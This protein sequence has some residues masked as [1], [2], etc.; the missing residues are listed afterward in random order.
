[1]A[2][3]LDSLGHIVRKFRGLGPKSSPLLIYRPTAINSFMTK[4]PII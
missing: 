2:I 1:M 3:L 4:V